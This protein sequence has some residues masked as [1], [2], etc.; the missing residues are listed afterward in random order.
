MS[1]NRFG[2]V[3]VANDQQFKEVQELLSLHYDERRID[4]ELL[5]K[6][7][8]IQKCLKKNKNMSIH[9]ART[10]DLSKI[11]RTNNGLG[12]AL[13]TA[14]NKPDIEIMNYSTNIAKIMAEYTKDP[15]LI[16]KLRDF[17]NYDSSN[18]GG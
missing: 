7:M 5:S 10:N 13:S 11:R 2:K 8:A 1:I 16:G 15:Y 14:L 12:A 4:N 17:K 6:L 3:E 9:A 18:N